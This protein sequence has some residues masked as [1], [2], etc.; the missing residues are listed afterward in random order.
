MVKYSTM[1]DA[2]RVIV[3]FDE[4]KVTAEKIVQGLFNGGF[5]VI[6]K[7]WFTK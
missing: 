5:E 4:E 1:P 6:G 7:P 2:N 3:T